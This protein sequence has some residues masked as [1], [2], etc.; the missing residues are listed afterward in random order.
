MT[1]MDRAGALV[2]RL[3]SFQTRI[4]LAKQSEQFETRAK[5]LTEAAAQVQRVEAMRHALAASAMNVPLDAASRIALAGRAAMLRDA[6]AANPE[7]IFMTQPPLDRSFLLPLTSLVSA[8]ESSLSSAWQSRVEETLGSMPEGLLRT[9][10]AIQKL[11]PQVQKLRD[12]QS[13]GHGIAATL[14]SPDIDS[15]KAALDDVSKLLVK[16][17][18]VL[19]ALKGIPEDVIAFLRLAANG[20]ARLTHLSGPVQEWLTAHGL[21]NEFRVVL[22]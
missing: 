11:A 15:V 10:G 5:Q 6:F 1:L 18:E 4:S 16:K 13:R 9:I 22:G 19:E 7:S 14:P 21:I 3:A 20:Q 8:M 2:A 17:S 12:I